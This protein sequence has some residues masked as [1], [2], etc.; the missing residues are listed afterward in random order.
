[1]HPAVHLQMFHRALGLVL[2]GLVLWLW[3]ALGR[4]RGAGPKPLAIR[5]LPLLVAAQVALG[6]LTVWTLKEL[7]TV[8][9]HLAVGTLLWA[10]CVTLLVRVRA[11]AADSAPLPAAALAAAWT[12]AT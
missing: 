3:L 7:V 2:A 9:G 5:A 4:V 12:R 11:T 8:T 10:A 1:M 6:F